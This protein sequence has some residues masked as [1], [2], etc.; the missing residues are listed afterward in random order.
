VTVHPFRYAL[1]EEL[2][3]AESANM[4]TKSGFRRGDIEYL[5]RWL[6]ADS[7]EVL[8]HLV[9]WKR[10]DVEHLKR[11]LNDRRA[12]TIFDKLAKGREVT[13]EQIIELIRTVL[14]ARQMAETVDFLNAKH[15]ALGGPRLANKERRNQMRRFADGKISQEA[16]DARLAFIKELES[17][18]PYLDPPFVIRSDRDGTRKRTIFC[19]IVSRYFRKAVL[20]R[21]HDNEV[22]ALCEIALDCGEVTTVQPA[23]ACL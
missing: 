2:T 23:E 7:F 4:A 8:N 10:G 6:N 20:G 21:W 11:W 17:G 18:I 3:L 9:E 12:A 16:L 1:K 19:R 13:R 22:A 15:A 14:V 5:K